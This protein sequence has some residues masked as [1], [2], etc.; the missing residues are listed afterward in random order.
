MIASW[1]DYTGHLDV[2]LS[3][4]IIVTILVVGTSF[5][6]LQRWIAW[7]FGSFSG[8]TWSQLAVFAPLYATLTMAF[9]TTHTGSLPRPAS[10]TKLYV[11]RVRGEVA[12]RRLGQQQSNN[13]RRLCS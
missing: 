1:D 6:Q 3:L 10:L 5:E 12:P 4:G 11:A 2:W 7:G 8:V 13:Q 9:K